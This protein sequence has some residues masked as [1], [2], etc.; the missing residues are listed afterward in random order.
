[1]MCGTPA[2]TITLSIQNPGAAETLLRTSSAPAGTRVMRMRASFMIAAG[3][4]DARFHHLDR[5]RVVADADAERLGDAVGRNVVV[6]RAD[7]AGGEH[8][9]VARAQCV[10]RRDDLRLLV[11]DDRA[12]P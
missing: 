10:E 3:F 9:D 2:M 7:A 8:I 5:L 6:G 1:M 11:G 4:G 12:L